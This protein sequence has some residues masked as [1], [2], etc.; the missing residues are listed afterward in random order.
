MGYL[1]L[2]RNVAI[3]RK[4]LVR[5]YDVEFLC[6]ANVMVLLPNLSI[7]FLHFGAKFRRNVIHLSRFV[8]VNS[9]SGYFGV[10]NLGPDMKLITLSC[11]CCFRRTDDN[12]SNNNCVFPSN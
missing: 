11:V 4:Y 2:Q 8:F 7:I 3:R 9:F 10:R 6:L 1:Q 5:V 12:T